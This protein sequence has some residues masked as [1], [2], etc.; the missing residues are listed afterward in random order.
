MNVA[1]TRLAR[2]AAALMLGVA[3]GCA[4]VPTEEIPSDA[5]AVLHWDRDAFRKREEILKGRQPGAPQREGVANVEN[6]RDWLG[7][8]AGAQNVKE[9]SRYPGHLKLLNPRTGELTRIEGAPSGARPLAWSADRKRLLFAS[10]AGR[11]NYQ[12]YEYSLETGDVH[13][14]TYGKETHVAADYANDGS[15]V[16]SGID[17]DK[18]PPNGRIYVME[19]SLGLP[20]VIT[21]GALAESVQLA[22]DG[23]S[24]VFVIRQRVRG[25]R[26]GRPLLVTQ[27]L[28]DHEAGART[29]GAGRHP[30]FTPDG[31]WIVYSAPIGDEWRLRRMR[32]DASAR[33]PMGVSVRDELSPAVSP[34]GGFVAYV[35]RDGELDRMFL[36]RLDGSGDRMLLADG[37][38]GFPVW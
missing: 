36:K 29:L 3:F 21:R 11:R 4:G 25:Q 20:K 9:L 32:P 13:A 1:C 5:I 23:E 16:F 28:T 35:A 17:L 30:V 14:V 38:F 10:A 33:R 37:S 18:Q 8:V 26:E 6:L 34:D 24:V 7:T 15:V 19:S 27:S 12:V 2:A 22:P 31:E